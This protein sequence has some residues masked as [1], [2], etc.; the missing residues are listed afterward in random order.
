MDERTDSDGSDQSGLGGYT[1]WRISNLAELLTILD[2]SVAGCG[3]GTPC[4][5]PVFGPTAIF[6]YWSAS[7]VAGFP[8]DAWFVNFDFGFVVDIFVKLSSLPVRA[9][10]DVP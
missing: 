7:T 2:T 10:R 5:D 4:I 9:V 6:R 1:D 8:N 3:S